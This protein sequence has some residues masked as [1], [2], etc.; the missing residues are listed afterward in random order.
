MTW[1][2]TKGML[3]GLLK[4]GRRRVVPTYVAIESLMACERRGAGPRER[5]YHE[6]AHSLIAMP[7]G[8]SH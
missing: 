1:H 6:A 4:A 8:K 5:E 3:A 7:S 2:C